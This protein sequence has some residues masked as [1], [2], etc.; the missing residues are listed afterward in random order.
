MIVNICGGRKGVMNYD[1]YMSAFLQALVVWRKG[2]MNYD[3]YMWGIPTI[4]DI[5]PFSI[6]NVLTNA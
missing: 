6:Y 4:S 1:P 5:I 3:S 2:V